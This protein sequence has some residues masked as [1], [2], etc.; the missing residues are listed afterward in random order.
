MIVKQHKDLPASNLGMKDRISLTEFCEELK[1]LVDVQIQ[2][3]ILY[4]SSTRPDYKP[5]SSHKKILVVV[6]QR[7]LA[8]LK[9]VLKPFFRAQR[10]GIDCEFITKESMEASTDVF[11][12][13]YQSM[14]ESYVILKGEDVLKDMKINRAHMRLRCEQEL[15][16]LSLKLEKFYLENHGKQLKDMLLN[17]IGDFIDTLRVAVLLKTGEMPKWEKAVEGTT[18]AFQLD[19]KVI[20]QIIQ[21]RDKTFSPGK[22]EIEELYDQFL[23]FVEQVVGIVDQIE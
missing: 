20:H 13:K 2:S 14:I 1:N 10:M 9:K 18:E 7:D 12:I 8:L 23:S 3:V 22:K 6:K 19:A 15:R 4:G 16:I 17:V 21:V 11:P 5:G